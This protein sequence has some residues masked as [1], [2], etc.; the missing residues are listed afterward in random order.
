MGVS[1]GKLKPSF[2]KDVHPRLNALLESV[3][4]FDPME[5]PMFEFIVTELD[6]ILT[7]LKEAVISPTALDRK[8]L[9]CV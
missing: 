8:D 2:P 4:S 7:K 9:I 3:L 6:E 5:R 1:E